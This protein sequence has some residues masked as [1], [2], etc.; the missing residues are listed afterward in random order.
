[1]SEENKDTKQVLPG[2][3]KKTSKVGVKF[4]KPW[5]RYYPSDT[6]GF[7]VDTAKMLIKEEIAAP[8]EK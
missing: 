1:M 7:D 4:L 3:A 8:A 2:A 5:N 6:A